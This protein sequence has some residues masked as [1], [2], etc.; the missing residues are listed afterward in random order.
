[1][2]SD[3]KCLK[4]FVVGIERT[5]FVRINTLKRSLWPLP[6]YID[7]EMVAMKRN[8]LSWGLWPLPGYMI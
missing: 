5:D 6:G 8:T 1:M 7:G 3:R 4:E 2:K